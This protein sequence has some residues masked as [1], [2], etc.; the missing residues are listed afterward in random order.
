MPIRLASRRTCGPPAWQVARVR[1]PACQAAS[2][3]AVQ[4]GPPDRHV[5]PSDFSALGQKSG[6]Q[7]ARSS[8]AASRS[9]PCSARVDGSTSGGRAEVESLRAGELDRAH[10]AVAIASPVL[11]AAAQAPAQEYLSRCA[12]C[13]REVPGKAARARASRLAQRCSSRA[14]IDADRVPAHQSATQHRPSSVSSPRV[15]SPLRVHFD[16]GRAALRSAFIATATRLQP[17]IFVPTEVQCARPHAG[18]HDLCVPRRSP[19]RF[20]TTTPRL[21]TDR[22]H[23]VLRHRNS[24]LRLRRYPRRAGPRALRRP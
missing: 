7:R 8:Q 4:C 9:R 5:R 3:S 1:Y 19:R 2:T 11:G 17:A 20:P 21:G 23:C 15:Q 13:R 16:T 18:G 10:R 24:L 14:A 22:E 12:E 6:V